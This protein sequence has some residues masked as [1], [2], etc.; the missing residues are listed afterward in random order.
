MATLVAPAPPEFCDWTGLLRLL[1][2]SY[3][4]QK[5]RIDP[6]SSVLALDAR[7]LAS[8]AAEEQLFLATDAGAL[9]GC[10]FARPKGQALYV[11]KLAV[12]TDRQGQGI[13]RRLMY[14][15]EQ[16][17]RERGS[18]LLEL[19]TRIELVEN[20]RTFAALGFRKTAE[21]AHPGYSRPTFIIMQKAL[22]PDSPQCHTLNTSW[23][24]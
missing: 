20:H 12:R 3:E 8:K 19:E 6:P 17:A 11:G 13:G 16:H 2:T 10:A 1:L 24:I 22:D 4:Y 5:D 7:A 9:V 15:V 14:A 21:A 23:R 18:D